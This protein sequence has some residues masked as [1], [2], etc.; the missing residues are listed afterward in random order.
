MSG[1]LIPNHNLNQ[2]LNRLPSSEP[3]PRV[4]YPMQRRETYTTTGPCMIVR[5]FGGW[6]FEAEDAQNR[7]P[8][9]IGYTKGVPMGGDLHDAPAGRVPTFLVA[10]LKTL[11][12]PI[13]TASRSSKASWTTRARCKRRSMT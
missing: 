11:S 5:S 2:S 4:S 8:G 9:Q 7:L 13:S 10:T 3:R 1:P 12:A 6:D